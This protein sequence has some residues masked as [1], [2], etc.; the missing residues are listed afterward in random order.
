MVRE[1]VADIVIAF[2]REVMKIRLCLQTLNWY[3]HG[4]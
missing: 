3:V 1:L 2:E 4:Q